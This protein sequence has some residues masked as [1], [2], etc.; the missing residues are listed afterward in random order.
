[1]FYVGGKAMAFD[2][3]KLTSAVNSYLYSI[4]DVNKLLASD[5]TESSSSLSDIF[6][7]YLNKA[8][9]DESQKTDEEKIDA[10]IAELKG[11]VTATDSTNTSLDTAFDGTLPDLVASKKKEVEAAE[12]AMNTQRSVYQTDA[13]SNEIA[14]A[15]NGLNIKEQIQES[16]ASHS[17]FSEIESFTEAR[18]KAYKTRV[19]T[20]T[21]VF[22]DFRL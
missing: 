18:I 9:D 13:L 3:S 12:N 20:D 6:L 7:K 15:F 19:N 2:V 11:A 17:R 16:I 5:S 1:M 14:S 21:S 22:G 10:A 8:V 4:S